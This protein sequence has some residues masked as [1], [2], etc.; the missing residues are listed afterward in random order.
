MPDALH[1]LLMHIVRNPIMQIESREAQLDASAV[2][3][4][5]AE[6]QAIA[7]DTHGDAERLAPYF[8]QGLRM[9]AA[10][11][12]PLV[13]EDTDPTGNAIADAFARYLVAPGLASSESTPIS[14]S[15]Y[16]YT[17]EVNWPAL[18]DL[19]SSAGIDLDAA[20]SPPS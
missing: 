5:P 6:I 12:G 8:A 15:H 14:R 19:A 4:V 17:F 13:V 18:R 2:Q 3:D 20:L 16:R 10:S 1:K 7:A 9:A 11:Q